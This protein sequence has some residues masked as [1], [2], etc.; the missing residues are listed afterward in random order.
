MSGGGGVPLR[1]EGGG[2]HGRGE[3]ED[4]AVGRGRDVGEGVEAGGVY[5]EE[6]CWWCCC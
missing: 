3:R 2:L 5:E 4:G 6:G 1:F